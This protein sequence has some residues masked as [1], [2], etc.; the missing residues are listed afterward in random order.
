MDMYEVISLAMYVADQDKSD[1]VDHYYKTTKLM[2]IDKWTVDSGLC[3]VEV[4]SS[5][6]ESILASISKRTVTLLEFVDMILKECAD[7]YHLEE[8]YN[9]TVC[10]PVDEFLKKSGAGKLK[11]NIRKYLSEMYKRRY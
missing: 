2:S 8:Y 9:T 7:S 10:Q 5:L 6:V 4:N 11:I 1:Q 3:A